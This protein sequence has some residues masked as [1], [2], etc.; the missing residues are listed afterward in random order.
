MVVAEVGVALAEV[1]IVAA[2]VVMVVTG[3]AEEDMGEEMVAVDEGVMVVA[4]VETEEDHAAV[5]EGVTVVVEEM[6]G[7]QQLFIVQ[8]NLCKTAT[9]KKTINWV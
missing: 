7:K 8:K 9:L 4:A 3:V 1:V 6:A 5:D 2:E